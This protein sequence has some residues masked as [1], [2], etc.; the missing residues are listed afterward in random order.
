MAT[1]RIS[2]RPLPRSA[3]QA[4]RRP[5][6]VASGQLELVVRASLPDGDRPVRSDGSEDDPAHYRQLPPAGKSTQKMA[7]LCSARL[8]SMRRELPGGY[9]LDDDSARIDVDA[10][11]GYLSEESYWARGP[12]ARRSSTSSSANGDARCRPVPRRRADRLRACGL[13]RRTRSR[14]SLTSTCYRSTAA[15]GWVS[16]SYVRRS[17]EAISARPALAAAHAGRAVPVRALRLRPRR[18]ERLMERSPG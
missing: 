12:G 5:V 18:R 8:G 7:Q 15:A 1:S 17:K 14:T 9:E 4:R 2:G 16:S 6:S 11:H 3:P 13:G 10:V